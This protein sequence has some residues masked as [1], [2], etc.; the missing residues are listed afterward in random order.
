MVFHLKNHDNNKKHD[1]IVMVM[2]INVIVRRTSQ[3]IITLTLLIIIIIVIH[4]VGKPNAIN[5]PQY[6]HKYV[7]TVIHK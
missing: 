7:V 5:H 6:H 3:I 1:R 4:N 2:T